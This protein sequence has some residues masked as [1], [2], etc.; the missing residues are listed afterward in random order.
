M[1][2]LFS[3]FNSWFP[4]QDV[5]IM[6]QRVPLFDATWYN[7]KKKQSSLSLKFRVPI[8]SMHS[9]SLFLRSSFIFC[10]VVSLWRFSSK[11]EEEKVIEATMVAIS[12]LTM[13]H[14]PRSEFDMMN[15]WFWEYLYPHWRELN[16]TWKLSF[17][18]QNIET[19]QH[20]MNH[21][22]WS[23]QSLWSS[24]NWHVNLFEMGNWIEDLNTCSTL[25]FEA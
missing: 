5:E 17:G 25:Q 19:M 10:L 1:C 12:L 14:L 9:L 18:I 13:C 22:E 20:V 23:E 2:H 24:F 16:P 6:D 15:E 21:L 7:A 11:K 3:L 4:P 8:V